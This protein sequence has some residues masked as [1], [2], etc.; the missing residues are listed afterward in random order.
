MGIRFLIVNSLRSPA[1]GAGRSEVES[2]LEQLCRT[3]V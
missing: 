1:V 3:Q 2:Q